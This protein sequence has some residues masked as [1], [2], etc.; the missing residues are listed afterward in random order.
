MLD[1]LCTTIIFVFSILVLVGIHEFGHYLAA[2]LSG[3]RVLQYSIGFGK[4]LL[5]WTSPRSSIT[6]NLR[7][8]P[9][10]GYVKLLMRD[11][12]KD[13]ESLYFGEKK[14]VF[15]DA[16][17]FNKAMIVL[18]G[19]VA[20]GLLAIVLLTYIGLGTYVSSPAIIGKTEGIAKEVGFEKFDVIKQINGNEV[21][22]WTDFVLELSVATGKDENIFLV[23]RDDNLIEVN[24][25][26]SSYKIHKTKK[27]EPNFANELGFHYLL[28]IGNTISFVSENS[29]AEKAGLLVNDI[30]L[31]LNGTE[32]NYVADFDRLVNLK[33]GAINT[34]VVERGEKELTKSLIT[35]ESGGF[36][37][38]LTFDVPANI[39]SEVINVEEIRLY[40][41][42]LN[43]LE[44]TYDFSK[45]TLKFIW[46]VIVNETEP[47]VLS[48]PVSMAQETASGFEGGINSYFFVIA[49]LSINLMVLNLLPLP[50]LDGGHLLIFLIEKITGP[51]NEKF[52]RI[53]TI[54]FI[55]LF[56]TTMTLIS[57]YDTYQVLS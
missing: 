41:S 51:I 50:V 42:F 33:K 9:L 52:L 38:V 34:F 45:F 16:P 44:K 25:D 20:N 35:P 4:A 7:M 47:S 15:E 26:L 57:I 2:R 1:F 40:E 29:E 39:L 56:A 19:P 55:I 48:G 22:T 37:I 46:K 12:T 10:G 53:L 23:K 36:G 3:V 32:F 27:E 18:C 17:L 21:E 6:Y 11:D 31:S 43:S 13:K 8:L 24:A 49:L 30:V 54:Y 14:G 28:E 5:S